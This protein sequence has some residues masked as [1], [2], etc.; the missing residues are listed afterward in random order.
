MHRHKGN[1]KLA[2]N[3]TASFAL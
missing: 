1:A 2:G 3:H